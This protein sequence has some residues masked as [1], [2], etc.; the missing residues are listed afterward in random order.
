V[1]NAEDRLQRAGLDGSRLSA[2]AVVSGGRLPADGLAKLEAR[3]QAYFEECFLLTDDGAGVF[4]CVLRKGAEERALLHNLRQTLRNF[5]DE[6]VTPDLYVG[7]GALGRPLL[8]IGESYVEALRALRLARSSGKERVLYWSDLGVDRVIA[9]VAENPEAVRYC[10]SLLRPL[11]VYDGEHGTDLAATILAL[12]DRAWNVTA[13]AEA[14]SVHYN[15][16]KYRMD[17]ALE[18]LGIDRDNPRDR[19]ALSLAVYIH[20][21]GP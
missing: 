1:R 20:R 6:D 11:F 8:C 5:L 19:F 17:K 13:A 7:I 10:G 16:V 4:V 15:T 3:L 9:A 18:I 14:L 12:E 2:V 21:L